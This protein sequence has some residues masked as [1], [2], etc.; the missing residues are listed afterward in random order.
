MCPVAVGTRRQGRESVMR[1]VS[2]AS[3]N[4]TPAAMTRTM[5]PNRAGKGRFSARTESLRSKARPRLDGPVSGSDGVLTEHRPARDLWKTTDISLRLE[6]VEST[7]PSLPHGNA[8][9]KG[10]TACGWC[11]SRFL[12]MMQLMLPRVSS[13]RGGLESGSAASASLTHGGQNAL[14][15]KSSDAGDMG[16]FPGSLSCRVGCPL[17]RGQHWRARWIMVLDHRV[18]PP[19]HRVPGAGSLNLPLVYAT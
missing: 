16:H 1:S 14:L 18:R 3:C 9:G 2:P 12:R 11:N 17:R 10:T 6:K 15:R 19:A 5:L 4:S 7:L 8:A 13:T